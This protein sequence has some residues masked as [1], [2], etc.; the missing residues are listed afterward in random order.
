M[1]YLSGDVEAS[2]TSS[3]LFGVVDSPSTWTPSPST[4]CGERGGEALAG[5]GPTIAEGPVGTPE[6]GAELRRSRH[7]NLT[8][9]NRESWNRCMA[10][11]H[12]ASVR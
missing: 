6:A 9:L 1:K 11:V 12:D 8:P 3:L 2:L 10:A 4:S 5:C 7:T